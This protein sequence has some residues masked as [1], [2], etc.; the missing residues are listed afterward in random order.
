ME[1]IL[2]SLQIIAKQD[3]LYQNK[4]QRLLI[5]YVQYSDVMTCRNGEVCTYVASSPGH[6]Q[7]SMLVHGTRSHVRDV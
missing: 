5:Y 6:S 2:L 4:V 7:L 1:Q 3:V